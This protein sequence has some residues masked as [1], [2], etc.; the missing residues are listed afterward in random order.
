MISDLWKSDA[1]WF[2]H[3]IQYPAYHALYD[4]RDGGLC[5]SLHSSLKGTGI[6]GQAET[7]WMLAVVLDGT[8]PR[9]PLRCRPWASILAPIGDQA[10][11][12]T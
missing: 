6:D 7:C 1:N 4:A 8:P 3:L 11:R 2:T 5:C 9:S 10:A 12:A